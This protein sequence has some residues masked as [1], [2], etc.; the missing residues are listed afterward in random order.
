MPTTNLV[1]LPEEFGVLL[2]HIPALRPQVVIGASK[3]TA[4][5][6]AVVAPSAGAASSAADTSSAANGGGW[7]RPNSSKPQPRTPQRGAGAATPLPA[8]VNAPTGEAAL[9]ADAASGAV[10]V[11]VQAA[12]DTHTAAAAASLTNTVRALHVMSKSD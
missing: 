7:S 8:A 10:S 1:Q 3:S 6:S 9:R 12:L 2:Q 5:V 4:P 11:S